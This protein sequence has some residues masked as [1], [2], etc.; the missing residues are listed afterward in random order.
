MAPKCRV[1]PK[2]AT[3]QD[4]LRTKMSKC[5]VS[6]L[7]SKRC[8]VTQ[9]RRVTFRPHW[10]FAMETTFGTNF[11]TAS[12]WWPLCA[13]A[14]EP[15][16]FQMFKSAI[17]FSTCACP[18]WRTRC[19]RAAAGGIVLSQLIRVSTK[20]RNGAR[21]ADNQPTG[22]PQITAMASAALDHMRCQPGR[23]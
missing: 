15:A 22:I 12:T 18:S 19:S 6:A 8:A 14:P 21:S 17:G 11:R 3:S 4:I 23:E 9:S 2:I 20:A 16:S 7:A 1:T 13:A 10:L 5:F